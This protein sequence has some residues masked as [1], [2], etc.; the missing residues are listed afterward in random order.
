MW[1]E[2]D[3][4]KEQPPIIHNTRYANATLRVD[5]TAITAVQDAIVWT[6]DFGVMI[7]KFGENLPRM[8]FV[9]SH[10]ARYEVNDNSLTVHIDHSN[11][12]SH[13]H[14][15]L[16]CDHEGI[17]AAEAANRMTKLANRIGKKPALH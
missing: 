11:N 15:P 7:A 12:D 6:D 14:L 5:G 3:A 4:W 16:L 1:A 17:D 9:E 13:A 10:N 2:Y 8:S